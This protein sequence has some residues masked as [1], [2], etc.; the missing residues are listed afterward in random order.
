MEEEI[1]FEGWKGSNYSHEYFLKQLRNT[2][3]TIERQILPETNLRELAAN[4]ASKIN[5]NSVQE[6]LSDCD[7]V[8]EWL[9]QDDIKKKN[10]IRQQLEKTVW[11]GGEHFKK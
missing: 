6:Y 1:D 10:K 11:D 9:V 8:Y 4:L 2:P 5:H 7:K 3:W